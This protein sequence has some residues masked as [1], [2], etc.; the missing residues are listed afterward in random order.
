MAKKNNVSVKCF[1]GKTKIPGIKENKQWKIIIEVG[2]NVKNC[3]TFLEKN[4]S[5]QN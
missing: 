2:R 5:N 3:K 4:N 1:Q